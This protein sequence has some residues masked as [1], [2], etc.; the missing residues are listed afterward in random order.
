M[1][2]FYQEEQK[3][4]Q[5][6]VT[7]T[8]TRT[9]QLQYYQ[10]ASSSASS[11]NVSARLDFQ[12]GNNWTESEQYRNV[13]STKCR[14]PTELE[15]G[16][17]PDEP[18]ND[19]NPSS[20]PYRVDE[21]LT[22]TPKRT[23]PSKKRARASWSSS[24][25]SCSSDYSSGS[26][27]SSCSEDRSKRRKRCKDT[28]PREFPQR[29]SNRSNRKYSRSSNS[30]GNGK[31]SSPRRISPQNSDPWERNSK[32]FSQRYCNRSNR[33]YSRSS[34]SSG[35]GKYS[36]PRRISP[37]NSGPSPLIRVQCKDKS[38]KHQDNRAFQS[39]AYQSN[40]FCQETTLATLR[41]QNCD[42]FS[43][44]LSGPEPRSSSHPNL[45]AKST[46]HSTN[47]Q[48]THDS[49]RRPNLIYITPPTI[50]LSN[51][52]G[53]F[54]GEKNFF[55]PSDQNRA[56]QSQFPDNFCQ[57]EVNIARIERTIPDYLRGVFDF[58]PDDNEELSNAFKIMMPQIKGMFVGTEAKIYV[59]NRAVDFQIADVVSL[60]G[61]LWRNLTKGKK[62]QHPKWPFVVD[63]RDVNANPRYYPVELTYVE[64]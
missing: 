9:F 42:N 25:S 48:F 49:W 6:T 31:Y 21:K 33:K 45:S 14:S 41:G 20:K 11:Q 46:F 3:F 40:D 47:V 37:D 64:I 29:Y 61:K 38:Q 53:Q 5:L 39:K 56:I 63:K 51:N 2:E 35:N 4:C 15:E 18:K 32:D 50:P 7:E 17:I 54:S 62:L 60:G 23:I 43:V 26:T 58:K 57:P 52:N 12:N 59:G 36:A 30:S 1:D 19:S 10:N 28:K 34:D 22:E 16:E 13:S 44:D 8:V 27:S 55:S 24:S